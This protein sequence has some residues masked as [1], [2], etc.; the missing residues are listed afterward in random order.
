MKFRL[1]GVN[2]DNLQIY[3]SALRETKTEYELAVVEKN[4]NP[5]DVISTESLY[6]ICNKKI[7]LPMLV[8]GKI[9]IL[10]GKQ[11]FS[12]MTKLLEAYK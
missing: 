6:P 2:G 4:T 7:S 9:I 12:Q 5:N 8:S 11:D 10:S 1:Y 3:E